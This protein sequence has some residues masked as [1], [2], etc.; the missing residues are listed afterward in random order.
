MGVP[1][2][3]GLLGLVR[4]FLRAVCQKA[5]L[6]DRSSQYGR[7]VVLWVATGCVRAGLLVPQGD[8]NGRVRRN[9]GRRGGHLLGFLVYRDLVPLVQRDRLRGGGDD[10]SS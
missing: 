4:G 3:H 5:W 7:L 1:T 9:A 8:R 2:G 6:V 10:G